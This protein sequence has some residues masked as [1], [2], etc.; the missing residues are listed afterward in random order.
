MPLN[1][2]MFSSEKTNWQTPTILY[3]YL[4]SIF[5]FDFD[6]SP[7]MPDFNGLEVEWGNSNYVNPPYGTEIAKWIKKAFAEYENGKRVVMLIPARTDTR[8]WHDYIMKA[9]D[10]WFVKG[11]LRF[12]GAEHNAPFPNAIVIFEPN[13]PGPVRI[14]TFDQSLINK[15]EPTNNG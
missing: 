13:L 11:R 7:T 6:P 10:I 14:T 15:Q 9:T 2:A 8:Y 12:Q 4:D 1:Q 5:E 3:E